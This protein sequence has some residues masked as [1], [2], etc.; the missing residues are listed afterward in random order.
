MIIEMMPPGLLKDYEH[1]ART[2]SKKQIQEIINSIRDFGFNTAIEVNTDLVILSGHARV[3]AAKQMGLTE[4]PVI[5]QRHLLSQAKQD[6]YIL[7]AN[8]IAMNAEWDYD[9][10][11]ERIHVL[12]ET[13]DFDLRSTGFSQNELDELMGKMGL[14]EDHSKIKNEEYK[15]VYEVVLEL[16]DEQ[17]QEYWYNRLQEEGVKCRVLSM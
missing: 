3:R 5:V 4:I 13:A 9:K 1:N 14:S 12:S 10:L 7:A 11:S 6:G 16:S 8:K 15:A 2:H 17:E